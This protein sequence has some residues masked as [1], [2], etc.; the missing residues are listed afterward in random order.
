MPPGPAAGARGQAVLAWTGCP[1]TPRP[2]SDYKIFGTGHS[3][4]AR[5]H[6]Y[7]LTAFM[8]DVPVLKGLWA[9]LSI[10][11]GCQRGTSLLVPPLMQHCD[12]VVIKI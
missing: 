5:G 4:C 6:A 7:R 12:A 3:G 1:G 10:Q 2:G 8:A 9:A 11:S